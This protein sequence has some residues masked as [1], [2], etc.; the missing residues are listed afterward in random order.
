MT[1]GVS[2][3]AAFR[4][5][6]AGRQADDIA[7][8]F[9]NG[10]ATDE[11]I[12]SGATGFP[13]VTVASTTNDL[14][15]QPA[16][17]DPWAPPVPETP[18]PYT[19]PQLRLALDTSNRGPRR[20]L[21][22]SASASAANDK[23]KEAGAGGNDV[24]DKKADGKGNAKKGGNGKAKSAKKAPDYGDYHYGDNGKPL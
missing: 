12:A 5:V 17:P 16:P 19:L 14:A 15:E 2:R 22:V 6:M 10:V 3:V 7:A 18:S 8:S 21:D 9:K 20:S 11:G 13:K 23:K 24:K 1:A 4:G